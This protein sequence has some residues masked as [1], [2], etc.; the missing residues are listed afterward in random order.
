MAKQARCKRCKV[1]YVWQRD[2]P[3]KGARCRHCGQELE[4]TSHYLRDPQRSEAPV[5]G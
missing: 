3:L 2:H 5:Y 1:H 4:R